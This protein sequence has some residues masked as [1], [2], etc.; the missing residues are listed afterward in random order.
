MKYLTYFLTFF[1]YVAIHTMRMSYSFVKPSFEKEFHLDHLFLGL[2]DGLV[3]LSLGI[4]F[5][6]RYLLEGKMAPTLAYLVFGSIAS[7]GYCIIPVLSLA[8]ENKISIESS[9]ILQ[10]GLPG[11]GLIM[12]GFCQFSAW[13][14][15]LFLV[16]QHF[17]LEK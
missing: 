13:P 6:M 3:Y 12:F 11:L 1:A 17:D 16:N 2:F 4:G 7:V 5:F 14:V 8:D 9:F 15:L 10:Y